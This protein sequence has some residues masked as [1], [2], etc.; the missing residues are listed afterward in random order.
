MGSCLH[1]L[2]PGHLCPLDMDAYFWREKILKQV[3]YYQKSYFKM[4]N[5]K[6]RQNEKTLL[7]VAS[8]A[9]MDSAKTMLGMIST[10]H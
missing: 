6:G 9:F 3:I 5:G 4:Q 8:T 1:A 7:I 2:K 10:S